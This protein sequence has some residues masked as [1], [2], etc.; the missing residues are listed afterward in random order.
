[1]DISLAPPD[2]TPPL[3]E[4]AADPPLEDPLAGRDCE[5]DRAFLPLAPP[6]AGDEEGLFLPLKLP[7]L[8]PPLLPL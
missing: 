3:V 4:E 8:Y 1:M 5:P 7:R 6:R 2:T